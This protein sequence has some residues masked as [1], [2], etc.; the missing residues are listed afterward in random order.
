MSINPG[1]RRDK[2][3][4][5]ETEYRSRSNLLLSIDYCLLIVLVL[6][7]FGGESGQLS[8]ANSP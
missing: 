4:R 5:G 7:A 8:M 2:E 6:R 3:K 1:K